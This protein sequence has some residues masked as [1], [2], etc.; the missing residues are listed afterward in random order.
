MNLSKIQKPFNLII[1]GA[2]GDL[3]NIKLFPALYELALQKRLPK[4]YQIVGFARSKMTEAQFRKRFERSIK[5]RCDKLT[6]DPK[7]LDE[8]LSHLHYFQGQY[9]EKTSYEELAKYL[10]KGHKGKKVYNLGFLAV[11]PNVFRPV[12]KNMAAIKQ[13]IGNEDTVEL[14]LEKPFGADRKSAGELF[15]FVTN[16]FDK[17]HLYLI[18]HYLGKAPVRSLFPL[19]YNNTILNLLLQGKAISN[20]QITAF[21]KAGV[22]ERI[23]FF[24][25]VGIVKDMIQSHLLQVLALL[26]KAMPL[27]KEVSSIRREKGNML[28]ALRYPDDECGIVLGQY[29][30]YKKQKGVQKDSTTPTFAALR[31]MMDL[32][33]WYQVPIYIRTGKKLSHKHTY[34]VVEFENPPYANK[35]VDHNRLI[36]ELHPGEKLSL[37]LVNDIGQ[38]MPSDHNLVPEGSLACM[39]DDCLPA[40]AT[41][42]LDAF[43]KRYESFLSIDEV[44]ASWHFI[45][46]LENC[47]KKHALKPI[48]YKEGSDGPKQQFALTKMDGFKWYDFD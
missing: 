16:Y 6:F 34:I 13:K 23:G 47:T 4:Q 24:D 27:K 17:K 22:D 2:S 42:V 30:S 18:D 8:L 39:G 9:D 43:L 33:E 41:L 12:I 31:C 28:S 11:P 7:V 40:Y 36:I 15:N 44:L 10:L 37:R 26:T 14:M 48:Q 32:T 3:A 38:N 19:R 46:S 45:D 21:E 20:I 25:Q 29:Q 1:F 5:K 35:K